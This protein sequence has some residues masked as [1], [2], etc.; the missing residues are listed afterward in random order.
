M[1][2]LISSLIVAASIVF[3]FWVSGYIVRRSAIRHEFVRKAVHILS[4]TASGVCIFFFESPVALLILACFFVPFFVIS[5][6]FSLFPGVY[7]KDR[8]SHGPAFLAAACG[9]LFISFWTEKTVIFAALMTVAWADSMAAV[10][11]TTFPYGEYSID[12][13]RRTL[14]GSLTMFVMTLLV[15]EVSLAGLGAIEPLRALPIAIACATFVTATESVSPSDADNLT[16]PLMCALIIHLMS[17]LSLS[18]TALFWGKAGFC[19]LVAIVSWRAGF[20]NVGGAVGVFLI[21]SIIFAVGGPAWIIPMFVF[22]VSS[23]LISKWRKERKG[24]LRAF[25]AKSG[26]RDIKQVLAKGGI[27]CLLAICFSF[28]AD[29]GL[30]FA[31]LC[32]LAAANADTWASEIGFLSRRTP[33]S[34]LNWRPVARGTSGGVSATGYVAAGSG[35]VVIGLVGVPFY[36]TGHL[37]AGPMFLVLVALA[38]VFA[39]T[40]DSILG[41][42]AQAKLRCSRCG[43]ITENPNHCGENTGVLASGKIWMNNEAVNLACSMTGAVFALVVAYYM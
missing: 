10:V 5:A 2:E 35:A 23:S 20:L 39:C 1:R 29:Q 7:R 17:P 43:E 13:N 4:G 34:I 8:P 28:K 42:A 36:S 12:G 30:Y 14:T 41:A 38:G 25:H 33:V 11:G 24:E 40:V 18:E 27:P 15:V 32:S 16:I 21:G 9:A 31:Y 6:R 3:F 26:P 19:M 37:K 22:F